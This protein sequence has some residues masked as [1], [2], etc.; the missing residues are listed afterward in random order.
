[1][2]GNAESR[3]AV[4]ID[5]DFELWRIEQE[6]SPDV[7]NLRQRLHLGEHLANAGRKFMKIQPTGTSLE[8]AVFIR[9]HILSF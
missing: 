4:T 3:S 1:L 6:I 8:L 5:G 7:H 2:G 9:K